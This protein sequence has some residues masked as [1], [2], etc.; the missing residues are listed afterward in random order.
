MDTRNADPR[1]HRVGVGIRP[2]SV[3]PA[4]TVTLAMVD[5]TKQ[6]PSDLSGRIADAAETVAHA[7]GNIAHEAGAGLL[8]SLGKPILIGGGLLL[9]LVLLLRSGRDREAE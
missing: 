5:A 8:S 2:G 4:R 1:D 6:A 9:G 3:V 7:I